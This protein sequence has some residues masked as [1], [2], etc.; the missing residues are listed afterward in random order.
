MAKLIISDDCDF[1]NH[2]S[3]QI[4][5]DND[6]DLCIEIFSE[7]ESLNVFLNKT[8]AMQMAKKILKTYNQK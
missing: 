6:N 8:S 4:E 2:T 3:Y 5:I 1:Y 7:G